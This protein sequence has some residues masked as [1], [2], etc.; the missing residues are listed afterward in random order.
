MGQ[1]Y[2]V[3]FLAEKQDGSKEIIR[4][5]IQAYPSKLMEHSYLDNDF[6]HMIEYYKNI[7]IIMYVHGVLR[8]RLVLQINPFFFRKMNNYL[9]YLNYCRNS[10][11]PRRIL[12]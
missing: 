8:R 5:W 11:Q 6:L 3:I 2:K 4:C 7:M 12:H 1:Y 10:F 9:P